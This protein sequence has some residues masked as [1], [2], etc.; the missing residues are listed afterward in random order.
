MKA[1]SPI[2]HIRQFGATDLDAVVEVFQRAIR[3][4]AA[5]DYD[6]YQIQAWS[7]VDRRVWAQRY[8][9]SDVYLA[10]IDNVV[11]GFTELEHNGHLNMM[12]VKPDAQRMGVASM[13]LSAVEAKATVLGIH[14]LSTEASITAHPFFESRGFK[15]ICAQTVAC[16][17]AMLMNYRMFKILK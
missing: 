12:F 17:G 4:S 11:S 2:V 16:R 6:R 13:L 8:T 9:D 1:E 5:Q 7:Q 15:T 3:E 14:R 10:L